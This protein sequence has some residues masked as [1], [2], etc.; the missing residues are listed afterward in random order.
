[1]QGHIG[2]D[3]PSIVQYEEAILAYTQAGVKVMIT[4]LDLSILPSPRPGIGAD[5]SASEE[6]RKE[7]NPY[8]E[9]V[10]AD[11]SLV[12]TNRMTDFFKL[13]LK[14]QGKVS[15]VTTWGISDGRSW[16]NNFPVRG[17]TDYP[18]LF[19]RNHQPKPVVDEII[20]LSYAP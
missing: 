2:T 10:P 9:G 4:E 3:S 15:R 6:Y 7:I 13:F 11:V 17:R 16:K 19:D 14:Y 12:W 5:L 8:T 18:L 20:K 1:M